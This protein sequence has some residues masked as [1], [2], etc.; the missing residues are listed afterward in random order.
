MDLA[1]LKIADTYYQ[2]FKWAYVA[3]FRRERWELSAEEIL[4]WLRR[5]VV[6]LEEPQEA[7]SL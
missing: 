1:G 5:S 7:I 2:A 4:D 6:G 3:G